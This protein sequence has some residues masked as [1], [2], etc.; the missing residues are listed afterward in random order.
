M[1]QDDRAYFFL[2]ALIIFGL[3]SLFIVVNSV[4]DNM[5]LSLIKENG[6]IEN[7]SA[8]C[9]LIVSLIMLAKG[10]WKFLKRYHYL[11][12][13]VSSLGLREL[14]FNARFTTMSIWKIK[15][16]LSTKVPFMEKII[17]IL[18]TF[19]LLYFLITCIKRHWRS[20]LAGCTKEVVSMSIG[21]SLLFMGTA[22][23]LDRMPDRLISLGMGVTDHF[24]VISQSME[25][26]LEL[27]IPLMFIVATFAYFSR[28]PSRVNSVSSPGKKQSRQQ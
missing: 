17:G 12:I 10:G 18:V 11:F 2:M 7:L 1:E 15:F 27:G 20:F 16:F 3:I 28:N 6:P 21:I 22:F 25:E 23:S 13:L 9:Y 14:D 4:D 5:R 8:A 26:I 19:I 24:P